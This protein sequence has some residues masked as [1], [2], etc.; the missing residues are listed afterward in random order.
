MSLVGKPVMYMWH[1]ITRYGVVKTEEMRDSWKH[2]TV[3]W[4]NDHV[5]A[6]S[7]Q[8]LNSLRGGEDYTKHIY[9]VDE[10]L[11]IDVDRHLKSLR[12]IKKKL[13]R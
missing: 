12:D 2:C 10:L 3:D 8:H 5:Y 7:I 13:K 4:V 9:R 6:D 11:F 1:N